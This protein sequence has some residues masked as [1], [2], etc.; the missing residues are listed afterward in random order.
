MCYSCG[1]I[2]PENDNDDP[3]NIT[4]KTFQEAAKAN[5]ETVDQIKHNVLELLTL[6]L[7]KRQHPVFDSVRKH[8][9]LHDS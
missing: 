8:L 2:M 9:H 1:C 5:G 6:T 4:E 7:H 3:R